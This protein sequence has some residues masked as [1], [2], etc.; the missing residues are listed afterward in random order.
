MTQ[1]LQAPV[2]VSFVTVRTL[3]PKHKPNISFPEATSHGEVVDGRYYRKDDD[4]MTLVKKET[5]LHAT[6]IATCGAAVSPVFIRES[7]L[8]PHSIMC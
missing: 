5:C 8:P 1:S 3:D 6:S 7:T 2:G 4:D